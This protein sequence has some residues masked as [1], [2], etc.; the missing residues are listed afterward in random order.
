[1]SSQKV[2]IAKFLDVSDHDAASDN[3]DVLTGA[4][5]QMTGVKHCT[6]ETDWVIDKGNDEFDLLAT[7]DLLLAEFVHI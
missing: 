4:G 5:M 1:M 3:K 6:A 2:Q 7:S